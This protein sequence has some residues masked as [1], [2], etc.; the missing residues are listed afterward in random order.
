[1][2]NA[3]IVVERLSTA[4]RLFPPGQTLEGRATIEGEWAGRIAGLAGQRVEIAVTRIPGDRSQTVASA[5]ATRRG[6]LR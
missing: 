5:L 3:G 6:W 1:M 4:I 2:D